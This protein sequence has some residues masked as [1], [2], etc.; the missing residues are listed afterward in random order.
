MHN[1]LLVLIRHLITLTL[2]EEDLV[3]QWFA[4]EAVHKCDFFLRPGEVS[5]KVA[6]VLQGVFHNFQSRDG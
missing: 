5:R 2:T 1:A 4:P 3:R 6:F